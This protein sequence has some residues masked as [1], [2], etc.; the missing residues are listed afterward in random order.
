MAS[1]ADFVGL[2]TSPALQLATAASVNKGPPPAHLGVHRAPG[3]S[4]ALLTHEIDG[5]SVHLRLFYFRI[6]HLV[7]PSKNSV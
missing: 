5:Q 2:F 6:S 3:W 4:D 1:R 7:A